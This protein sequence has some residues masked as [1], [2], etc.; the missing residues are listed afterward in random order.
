MSLMRFLNGFVRM[1]IAH[2]F[3]TGGCYP[4]DLEIKSLFDIGLFTGDSF[5][6]F[7]V[8]SS[9]TNNVSNT[10]LHR[11]STS[12]LHIDPYFSLYSSV[13]TFGKSLSKAHRSVCLENCGISDNRAG[14]VPV[15]STSY[16]IYMV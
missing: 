2:S 3:G 15:N 12:S 11:L 8:P 7:L 5:T 10:S 14:L 4:I 1:R 13:S 6:I 16:R 9:L